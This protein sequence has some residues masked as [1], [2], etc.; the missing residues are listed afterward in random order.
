VYREGKLV[1]KWDLDE[2]KAMR[3]TASREIMTIITR[4]EF[5]GRL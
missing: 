1:L 3:G 2:E 4:L 5:E